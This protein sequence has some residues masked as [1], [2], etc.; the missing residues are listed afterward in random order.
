MEEKANFLK[1]AAVKGALPRKYWSMR[2]PRSWLSFRYFGLT[3][4]NFRGWM[5][6]M[7]FYGFRFS[8]DG[9]YMTTDSL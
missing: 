8:L 3:G 5:G 7:V 2:E 9:K 4:D 6:Y 1:M